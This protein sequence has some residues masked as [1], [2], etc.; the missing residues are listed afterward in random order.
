MVEVNRDMATVDFDEPIS[1]VM[2]TL[3]TPPGFGT[4]RR[5]VPGLGYPWELGGVLN[6]PVPRG[7]DDYTSGFPRVAVLPARGVLL[8]L[9]VGDRAYDDYQEH[10]GDSPPD[11]SPEPFALQR[12]SGRRVVRSQFDLASMTAYENRWENVRTWF[13][14]I[15]LDGTKYCQV[16]FFAGN[17][18]YAPLAAISETIASLE[19][20][21]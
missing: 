11:Q 3:K 4:E 13:R 12:A 1:G 16:N 5:L 20:H 7:L 15:E 10:V 17:S 2:C 21:V 14:V 8:W 9:T 18:P 6:A 19:F